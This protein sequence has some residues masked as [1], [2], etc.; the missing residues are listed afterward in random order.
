MRYT[1]IPHCF[2]K[3]ISI[4]SC[5]REIGLHPQC[6]NVEHDGLPHVWFLAFLQGRS[7]SFHTSFIFL[8]NF[9]LACFQ[10]RKVSSETTPEDMQL[11]CFRFSTYMK[12]FLADM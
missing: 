5:Y 4:F 2:A 1:G 10:L 3:H 7:R 11:L 9:D 6:L 8:K 12:M